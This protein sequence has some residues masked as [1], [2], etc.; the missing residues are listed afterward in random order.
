MAFPDEDRARIGTFVQQTP[1]PCVAIFDVGTR[2]VRLLVA[3]ITVPSWWDH[4]TFKSDSEQTHLGLDIDPSD[5]LLALDAPSLRATIEFIR[6]RVEFLRAEGVREISVIGT[7]WLRWLANQTEVIAL[8][9]SETGQRIEIIEQEREA[10][11]T[12]AALP[13]VLRCTGN[14]YGL[15]PGDLAL[16]F[17]QGGGSLEVSWMEW[18]QAD[19]RRPVIRSERFPRLGT[20]ELT[21]QFFH[22]SSNGWPVN[23]VGNSS[24]VHAQVMRMQKQAHEQLAI[25]WRERAAILRPTRKRVAF[26]VGTAITN[27]FDQRTPHVIHGQ[28]A[29]RAHIQS[30]L[31]A[32]QQEYG[33]LKNP[34]LTVHKRLHGLKGRGVASITKEPKAIQIDLAKLYGLPVY[35]E[36]LTA[37]GLDELRILGYPLRFGYY[38]WKYLAD[39]AQSPIRPD[40]SG[41]Y[42]FV[43]YA[44]TDSEAV[45]SQ[46][47]VL[48]SMGVRVWWDEGIGWG[49][50]ADDEIAVALEKS[51]AVLWCSSPGWTK[52][53]YAVEEVTH[54]WRIRKRI[55]QLELAPAKL[56]PGLRMLLRSRQALSVQDLRE[57]KFRRA[58]ASKIPRRCFRQ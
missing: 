21:R 19:E 5:N 36:L 32:V 46:L 11:L 55:L 51:A 31:D 35:L 40:T 30:H 52:S 53:R 2:S 41:P 48:H 43:S 25:D 16:L 39:D 42:V 58:I 6:D 37:L 20:V 56:P 45:F 14:N 44:H 34:V 9:E 24:K 18:G 8:I 33:A 29:S 27:T 17:D 28:L 23:P 4:Q 10:E 13:E 57:D 38:L 50:R 22:R 47:S 1:M 15:N 12:I 49:A 26:A 54:A 3:P 7:A